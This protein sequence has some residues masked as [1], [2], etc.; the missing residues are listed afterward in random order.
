VVNLAE[1][2]YDLGPDA[3]VLLS[4]SPLADGKLPTDAAVWL[5]PRG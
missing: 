2:P 5:G 4:S 3:H 1:E